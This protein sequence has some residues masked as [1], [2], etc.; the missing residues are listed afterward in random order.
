MVTGSLGPVK[1]VRGLLEFF[2]RILRKKSPN[3]PIFFSG[4]NPLPGRFTQ[5][6][7]LLLFVKSVPGRPVLN[8]CTVQSVIHHQ[9]WTSALVGLNFLWGGGNL[10]LQLSRFH[11]ELI[12]SKLSYSFRRGG[13]PGE[14]RV[15][16]RSD[17]LEQQSQMHKYKRTWRDFH[18]EI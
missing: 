3:S 16:I 6:P 9:S 2:P 18:R 4:C 14:W 12:V 11:L 5:L 10:W 8:T 17:T 7:A 15:F 13:L 1:R